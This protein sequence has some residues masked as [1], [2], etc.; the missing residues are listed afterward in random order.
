MVSELLRQV[1]LLDPSAQ[2]DRVVDIL[3]DAGTVVAISSQLTDLTDAVQIRDCKGLILGPGLVDLYSY[4]GEP[5]FEARETLQSLAESAIAGGF[6]RLTLLPEMIPALDGPDGLSRLRSQ[7]PPHLP[8]QIQAWGAITRNQAGHQLVDLTELITAGV[9][10]FS[11]G[12]PINNLVQLRRL[13]EYLHPQAIPIALWPCDQSLAG[14]GVVREGIEALRSGLPECPTL[15]ETTALAALLELVAVVKTPIHVI[16]VSTARSVQLLKAA[17]AQGLPV[18]A[19]TTWMHLLWNSEAVHTYD[20]NLHLNPP[21]GN[22]ADQQAL[23]EGLETGVLDAIAID[24]RSYTYEEKRQSFSESL[25]GAIGLQLALP[26]LWQTFVASRRWTGLDLWRYL[27]A[28]PAH[29]LNQKPPTITVGQPAEMTL[30]DPQAI[31]TANAAALRSLGSNT[32]YL[33]QSICGQVLQ[34]WQR[35][36]ASAGGEHGPDPSTLSVQQRST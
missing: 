23:I 20:S 27:S 21:L 10:G 22:P 28:Q 8:L 33:G 34:T 19:S 12:R 5:G 29:C 17:K 11:D 15:A 24:H 32:P 16:R 30:F 18:T 7:A 36:C 26:L 6:T 13:L 25:P 4:S 1:R 9:I 3:L 2:V 14:Q 35:N 31:W